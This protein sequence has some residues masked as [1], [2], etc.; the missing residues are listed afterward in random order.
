MVELKKAKAMQAIFVM[1]KCA[2]GRA[3]VFA[4]KLTDEVDE[5]S[6]IDSISRQYDLIAKFYLPK[7]A[8]IYTLSARK[9]KPWMALR[10]PAQ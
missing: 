3:Y 9:C 8:S 7:D 5:I 2:L 6:E 1:I 10:I 4:E